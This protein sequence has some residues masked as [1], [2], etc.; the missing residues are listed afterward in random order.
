MGQAP[1]LPASHVGKMFS[2]KYPKQITSCS[3][4]L[5]AAE[6]HQVFAVKL[7]VALLENIVPKK[8]K[9]QIRPGDSHMIPFTTQ[10]ASVF[11]T[12]TK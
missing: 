4:Y 12:P 1:I 11:K 2:G 8:Y 9:T 6:V 7:H 5:L 3:L 10:H